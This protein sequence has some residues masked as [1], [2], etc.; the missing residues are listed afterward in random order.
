MLPLT[1]Q[2]SIITFSYPG[3]FGFFGASFSTS[4]ILVPAVGL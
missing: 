3:L 4:K 1:S 2:T